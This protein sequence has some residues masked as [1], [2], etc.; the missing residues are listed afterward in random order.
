MSQK[1]YLL[2]QFIANWSKKNKKNKSKLKYWTLRVYFILFVDMLWS[3]IVILL[4]RV[5]RNCE[6]I[7]W[8]RAEVCVYFEGLPDVSAASQL[9]RK[10]KSSG[11]WCRWMMA[12]FG[13]LSYEHRP[14]KRPRLGPPDVYPQDPKQKEVSFLPRISKWPITG[15]FQR[16]RSQALA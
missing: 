3:V 10:R 7:F 14:L 5:H 13:I 6:F 11:L 1:C 4:W 8:N 12:A 2:G 16:K 9:W 15:V